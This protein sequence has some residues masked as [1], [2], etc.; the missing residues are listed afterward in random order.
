MKSKTLF[1]FILYFFIFNVHAIKKYINGN[2][3]DTLKKT[4]F[5][6]SDIIE[7][8]SF[9]CS[10]CY[11]FDSLY[12]KEIKK[13]LPK[14][15][16]IKQYH[17]SFLGGFMGNI[18]TQSWSVAIVLGIE[19]KIKLRI[20]ENIQNKKNIKN[21]DDIKKIFYRYAHINDRD[22]DYFLNSIPVKFFI[23]QQERVAITTD[24]ISV[25]TILVK[26]KYLINLNKINHTSKKFFVQEC[27]DIIKYLLKKK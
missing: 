11:K 10:H 23:V 26:G 25:P 16:K 19:E 1:F 22:Y 20:F 9:Y 17:V 13:N 7:F 15:I 3:Y 6:E 21:E 8:F 24:L 18:L 4:I 27:T 12:F 2:H 14:K 5:V